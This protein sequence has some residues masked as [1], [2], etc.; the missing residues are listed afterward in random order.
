MIEHKKNASIDYILSQGFVERQTFWGRFLTMHHALGLRF[1]FWDL[2]YSL[3]FASVTLLGVV[4][5]YRHAPVYDFP[6]ATATLFSPMLFVLIMA[7]SQVNERSCNLHEL[8]QTCLYT[9]RQVSALRCMY[10]SVA[11]IGFAVFIAVF[12][13]DTVAQFLSVLPLCLGGIFLCATI[14]LSLM[15]FTHNNWFVASASVLWV[16]VNISLPLIFGHRWE[17]LLA[18]IPLFATGAFAVGGA[19]LFMYQL[20]QMLME[21]NRYAI[22]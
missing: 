20:N 19:G 6:Y 16:V 7:F 22:A 10:Y 13:T 5:L 3:I 17:A 15:R 9:S 21:E 18:S 4:F 1:I 12:S 14:Q 11:G 8:K 2:G